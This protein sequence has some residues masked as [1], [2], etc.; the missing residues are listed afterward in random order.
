[1][2]CRTSSGIVPVGVSNTA[3]SFM[4]FQI[5]ATPAFAKSAYS[6][7]HQ[8]RVATLVKSGKTLGVPGGFDQSGESP[9]SAF[10]GHTGAS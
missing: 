8:A 1:M 2:S 10:D 3:G 4:S 6:P 9:S 7:P 5:P